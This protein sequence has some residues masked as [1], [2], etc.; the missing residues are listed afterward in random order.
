M[1]W[2]KNCTHNLR[3]RRGRF[4]VLAGITILIAAIIVA[5][6]VSVTD[7]KSQSKSD[8][9]I[10]QSPI[11]STFNAT[12]ISVNSFIQSLNELNFNSSDLA[13]LARSFEYGLNLSVQNVLQIRTI[14]LTAPVEKISKTRRRRAVQCDQNV[15]NV[16]GSALMFDFNLINPP[17]NTCQ[18][19]TCITEMFITIYQRFR[20]TLS[21]LINFQ[22]KQQTFDLCSITPLSVSADSSSEQIPT[23]ISNITTTPVFTNISSTTVRPSTTTP[24]FSSTETINTTIPSTTEPVL[25]TERS[26]LTSNATIPA[27]DICLRKLPIIQEQTAPYRISY[28]S[29]LF[30][31]DEH[32]L[33]VVGASKFETFLDMQ[34]IERYIIIDGV[35]VYNNCQRVIDTSLPMTM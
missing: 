11:P 28:T 12:Y 10:T 2:L 26:N 35:M 14:D 21:F 31:Q 6:V 4:L 29:T 20:S 5:I 25:S 24:N 13:Q 8:L 7:S 34:T 19:Q 15:G 9:N 22:N 23:S 3:T 16:N 32:T 27:I 30:F 18:S 17:N 1:A 33:I